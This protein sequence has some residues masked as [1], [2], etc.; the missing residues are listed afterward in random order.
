[1][2][3]NDDTESSESILDTDDVVSD[4][5]T[6]NCV[7]DDTLNSKPNRVKKELKGEDR[8]S[9]NKLT[10]YEMVRIIGERTKQ[11]SMGA[12]ALI[13]INKESEELTYKEIA[14]EELKLNMLPF[15]IKRPH[16]NSYEVWKLDELEKDHLISFF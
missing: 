16:Y 3:K 6:I 11:L 9:R 7:Y 1:M 8:I 5:E 13:R 10:R 14:I 2:S 4:S 12:K 15:K